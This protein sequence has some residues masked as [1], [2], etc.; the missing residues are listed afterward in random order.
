MHV[1]KK[2]VLIAVLNPLASNNVF[3]SLFRKI[4]GVRPGHYYVWDH[5]HLLNFIE[6]HLNLEVQAWH[7]DFVRAFTRR[8]GIRRSFQR[9]GVVR[10]IE[11]ALAN[12]FPFFSVSIIV[13]AR[14][15]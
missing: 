5:R 15:K 10:P 6:N 2:Y 12:I 3:Y 11:M 14:K 4:G 1:A 13:V 7:G 8:R 9:L